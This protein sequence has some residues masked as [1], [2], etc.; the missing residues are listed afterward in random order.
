MANAIPFSGASDAAGGFILPFE[1]GEILTQGILSESGALSLAGDSRATSARKEVF[2]I[3]LG[4]P[5]AGFVGEGGTKLATGGEFGAGTLNVKKVASIV[6]FTDEMIEDVQAGDLNVLSDAGVRQAISEVID[7]NAIGMNNGTAVSSNFDATLRASTQMVEYDNTTQDGLRLAVS[8]AMGSL[9]AN[10]YGNASNM[11]VLLPGDAQV[12]LRTQRQILSGT[13]N[14]PLYGQVAN[15][16]FYGLQ[17]AF[18]TNLK[19]LASTGGTATGG[20]AN[21]KAI[22]VYKPNLHVRVR[23]DVT[24]T[25]SKEAMVHDGTSN[26]SLFQENLTAIRYETRLGFTVHDINR[27]VVKIVD[28][29]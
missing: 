10:G 9:E 19:T 16:P 3:W 21:V 11:G 1:Q 13:T 22:V 2:A 17:T 27:A 6:L 8:A 18:S 25:S 29:A 20:T 14:V 28:A 5:T 7:V 4:R 12:H 24:V 26:R 23:K 15:D